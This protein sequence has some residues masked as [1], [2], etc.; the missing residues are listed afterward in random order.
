MWR[1]IPLILLYACAQPS[2]LRGS[3]VEAVPP[4]G[5]SKLC[6]DQPQAPECPE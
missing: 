4:F 5:Y 3:G 1:L 2:T 6:A